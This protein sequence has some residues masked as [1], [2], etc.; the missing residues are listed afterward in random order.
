VKYRRAE[1]GV[2]L[3]A[4]PVFGT[5]VLDHENVAVL[6]LLVFWHEVRLPLR[7][8]LGTLLSGYQSLW[9]CKGNDA[10]RR[11]V[12]GHEKAPVGGGVRGPTLTRVLT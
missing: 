5:D 9:R 12:A 10:Q 7:A 11:P 8:W 2:Y 6:R 3:A 1:L 4:M